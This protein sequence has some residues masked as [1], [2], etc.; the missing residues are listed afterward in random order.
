VWHSESQEPR[1]ESTAPLPRVHSNSS[2][3]GEPRGNGNSG[4]PRVIAAQGVS[5][6][7][8]AVCKFL[9]GFPCLFKHSSRASLIFSWVHVLFN[10]CCL[11]SAV[12]MPIN[13]EPLPDV[14]SAADVKSWD[15]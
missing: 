7:V 2:Q 9:H 1:L 6:C 8:H 10:T 5:T 15:T 12:D 13:T 4:G 14:L 3:L 11:C